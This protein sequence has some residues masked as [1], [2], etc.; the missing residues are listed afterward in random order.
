MPP[1]NGTGAARAAPGELGRPRPGRILD[2]D[3]HSAEVERHASVGE[4]AV[5]NEAADAASIQ[6]ETGLTNP[7]EAPSAPGA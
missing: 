2:D 3:S 7:P 4:E 5:R 1:P 6:P